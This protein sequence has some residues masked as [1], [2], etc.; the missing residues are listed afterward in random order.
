MAAVTLAV[1]IL[2][3][4][5]SALLLWD[6]RCGGSAELGVKSTGQ[7]SC[8]PDVSLRL[9]WAAAI[10]A[11]IGMMAAPIVYPDPHMMNGSGN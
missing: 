5:S 6:G 4:F 7:H 2:V 9:G 3:F 10:G 11:V 8:R 1:L